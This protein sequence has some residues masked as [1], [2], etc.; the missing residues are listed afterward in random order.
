MLTCI[1]FTFLFTIQKFD[2]QINSLEKLAFFN[3]FSWSRKILVKY[4]GFNTIK[5]GNRSKLE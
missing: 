3:F 1:E 2:F 5:Y 4:S